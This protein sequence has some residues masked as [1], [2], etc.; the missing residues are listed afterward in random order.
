MAKSYEAGSAHIKVSPNLDGFKKTLRQK[1]AAIDEEFKVTIIPDM[2]TYRAELKKAVEASTEKATVEVDA[3]TAEAEQKIDEVTEKQNVEIEVD[4]DTAEAEQKIDEVTED[5]TVS[6]DVDADT[7]DAQLEIEKVTNDTSATVEVDA[8]TAE[9]EAQITYVAR[10]RDTTVDVH[11]KE[12]VSRVG[13]GAAGALGGAAKT[14]AISGAV[15]GGLAGITGAVGA[16]GGGIGAL[17][18]GFVGLGSTALPVIGAIAVGFNGLGDALA[19]DEEAF[20]NLAPAAQSAVEAITGFKD[21]W[22]ELATS[23]QGALFEGIGESIQN[24]GTVG[25]PVL[26]AGLTETAAGFATL[27]SSMM[28]SLAEAGNLAKIESIMSGTRV[29][30]EGLSVGMVDMTSGLLT[31][32]DTAATYMPSISAGFSDVFGGIGEAVENLKATGELDTLMANLGGTLSGVGGLVSGLLQG[33]GSMGAALGPMFGELASSLG[34]TF[35][36][37]GQPLGELGSVFVEAIVPVFDAIGPLI[38]NLASGLAPALAPLG[39]L[40]VAI[41]EGLGTIAPTLGQL[42][43]SLATALAPV[44]PILA[45]I[46]DSVGGALIGVIDQLAPSLVPIGNALSAVVDALAPLLPVLGQLATAILVPLAGVIEKVATALQPVIE[47]FTSGLA[48]I[49]EQIAPIL[50]QV[51]DVLGTVLTSA[52]EALLPLVQGLL[53]GFGEVFAA[54]APL[55][56]QLL[57]LALEALTPLL[58]AMVELAPVIAQIYPLFGQVAGVLAQVLAAVMPLAPILIELILAAIIPILEILPTLVPVLTV[59]IEAFANLVTAII[60][61]IEVLVEIIEVLAK[62]LGYIVEWVAKVVAVIVEWAVKIIGTIIS[63]A[64]DILAAII[65]FVNDTVSW[66]VSLGSRLISTVSDFMSSVANAFST[67]VSKAIAFVQTLPGKIT[68]IFSSA[69]SWLVN[70]G[71]QILSGLLSGL[72]SMLPSVSGFL[73]RVTDMIPDWKGPAERDETLLVNAG[74]LVMGG[75]QKGLTNMFPAV[76]T[77]LTDFTTDI[78]AAYSVNGAATQAMGHK[79]KASTPGL[80]TGPGGPTSDRVLIAASNGEYIIP[81][82]MTE[83][84]RATLDAIRDNRFADG[85]VVGDKEKRKL[86]RERERNAQERAGGG[87]QRSGRP[88][89]EE[90]AEF[91]KGVDGV[92]YDWGAQKWGK[93]GDCSTTVARIARKAVGKDPWGGRFGT[94]TQAESLLALGF[95]RGKGKEGDLQIGWWNDAS[96]QGGG[97]TALTLPNGVN[98]EMGGDSGGRYG[99]GA[100]G[101]SDPSF[102]QHMYLPRS[103]FRLATK[104]DDELVHD[105]DQEDSIG[106]NE[107]LSRKF[108]LS[109][110]PTGV[111]ALSQAGNFTPRFQETYGIPEDHAIVGHILNAPGGKSGS[112]KALAKQLDAANDPKGVRALLEAGVWTPRFETAFNAP[113][114]SELVKAIKTARTKGGYK[115]VADG[116]TRKGKKDTGPK[117]WSEW[118]GL[119]A[120]DATSGYVKDM[121]SVTGLPDELPPLMKAADMLANDNGGKGIDPEV[122]KNLVPEKLIAGISAILEKLGVNIPLDTFPGF[123]TGGLIGG[124]GTGTSDSNLIRASRGEFMATADATKHARPLLEA[125]NANPAVG[126]AAMN[127]L[128]GETP[129]V[130]ASGDTYTYNIHVTDETEILARLRQEETRRAVATL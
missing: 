92:E 70:A 129:T 31:L 127:A 81:A 105:W 50:G 125:M 106:V 52:L 43:G 27:T 4:A 1:L 12:H 91:A 103:A 64:A 38:S 86:K 20:S 37:I 14:A 36:E 108:N 107:Q 101:A 56:P 83:K 119:Y 104:S 25:L 121:L 84:H 46:L 113:S 23:V 123:A 48:P 97:H 80:L 111:K 85:G 89:I 112:N 24:L 114:D 6:I 3:D 73:N 76:K 120:K 128:T 122:V 17:G 10:N 90:L 68:G 69:G 95:K 21:Q 87:A 41:G 29:M 61:V 54:I 75:F 109:N 117:S 99:R 93:W 59:V 55:L 30:L 72:K 34:N 32:G 15:G 51:G 5:K 126:V 65:N 100:I 96:R 13:K 67:G 42:G 58:D 82:D 60:P 116:K 62:V 2:D 19:G 11:V 71:S 45:E 66:F 39:Q 35:A 16:L 78:G 118:A 94:G 9:A 28:D 63:W 102:N 74:E 22:G 88:T 44:L 40:L 79:V 130:G 18:L 98:V 33:L 110:D 115:A 124:I 53:E 57:E 77:T 7:T 49:L 47:A 26:S 8:D